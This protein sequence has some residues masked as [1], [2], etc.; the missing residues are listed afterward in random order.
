MKYTW[1]DAYL[2]AKP[3]IEKDYKAEWGWDR[4][5]LHEKLVAAVCT[6][7]EKH[8]IYGGRPLVNLKGD[9]AIAEI[10]RKTYPDILPGFYCDKRNWN[11]VFLDGAVPEEVLREM[12]DEAYRLI[13][14]KLP[15]KVRQELTK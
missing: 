12:L 2:L 11:A 1:L 5:R 13:L 14:E 3:G 15:K 4:Y 10:L 6:P 7:D 9:P 8:G